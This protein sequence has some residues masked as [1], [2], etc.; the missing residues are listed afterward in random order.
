MCLLQINANKIARGEKWKRLF[1]I[2]KHYNNRLILL[3]MFSVFTCNF[4]I[5]SE[6]FFFLYSQRDRVSPA[7]PTASVYVT[8]S[9]VR[10]VF[11]EKTPRSDSATAKTELMN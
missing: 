5:R 7:S 11:C 9:N 3:R 4:L 2:F 8:F 6:G 10:S 1:Y